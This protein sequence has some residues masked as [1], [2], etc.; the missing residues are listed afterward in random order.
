MIV[1]KQERT[2]IVHRILENYSKQCHECG[3]ELGDK[4]ISVHPKYCSEKCERW[5]EARRIGQ[6]YEQD[7]RRRQDRQ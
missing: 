5:A 2:E 1:A 3:A 6:K 4:T 7:L